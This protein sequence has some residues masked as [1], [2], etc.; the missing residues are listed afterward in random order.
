MN[1]KQCHQGQQNNNPYPYGVHDNTPTQCDFGITTTY[2]GELPLD[3][4]ESLPSAIICERDIEDP[5]TG[6]IKRSLTRVPTERLIPNGNYDN[7]VAIQSNNPSIVV[8]ENQ[9]LAGYVQ[10]EGSRIVVYLADG[11]HPAQFLIVGN[12]A[13][14]QILIQPT[15]VVN[16]PGGHQYISVAQYYTGDKGQP[17][18]ENTSGQKLFI[19]ISNTKLLINGF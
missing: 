9:V 19:P 7:I 3:N 17:T 16:I 11:T 15:G 6:D 10:N 8:P 13:D 18:T 14:G 2:I 1:C 4:I 5:A 12:L